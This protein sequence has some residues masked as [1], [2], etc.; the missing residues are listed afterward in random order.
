MLFKKYTKPCYFM[1]TYVTPLCYSLALNPRLCHFL[2]LGSAIHG[3]LIIKS[4]HSAINKY[5]NMV[6]IN[7]NKWWR[8]S[9]VVWPDAPHMF[10]IPAN[11]NRHCCS[12]SS[13]PITPPLEEGYYSTIVSINMYKSCL[14][15]SGQLKLR[16]FK[17]QRSVFVIMH[18][19]GFRFL[20]KV[21]R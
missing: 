18:R 11:R 6:E 4:V 7:N 14:S 15:A 20:P 21:W 2:S 12:F 17:I 5:I 1:L 3:W 16:S 9:E 10:D 19:R 13:R 8:D